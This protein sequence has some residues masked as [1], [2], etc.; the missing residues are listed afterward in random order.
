MHVVWVLT[1]K[2]KELILQSEFNFLW[3]H[4][5]DSVILLPDLLYKHCFLNVVHFTVF[6]ISWCNLNSTHFLSLKCRQPAYL[7]EDTRCRLAE[8]GLQQMTGLVNIQHNYS[9]WN[10]MQMNILRSKHEINHQRTVSSKGGEAE[11]KAVG[12]D[13]VDHGCEKSK[14]LFSVAAGLILGRG[15]CVCV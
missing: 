8:L 9:T 3:V 12:E 10:I 4:R 2:F 14:A 15:L 6:S 13:Y 5:G 7:N 1:E 11:I